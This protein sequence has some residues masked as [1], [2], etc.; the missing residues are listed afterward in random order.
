[1]GG[2]ESAGCN[3]ALGDKVTGFDSARE[4]LTMHLS[5]CFP[6]LWIHSFI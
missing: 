3:V 4:G 6:S 1:M 5:V 2:V